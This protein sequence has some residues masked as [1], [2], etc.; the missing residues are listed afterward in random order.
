MNLTTMLTETRDIVGELTADFWT[1]AEL[2]R[3][4]NEAL[5][6]VAGANRWSWLL[7]EGTG[8]IS[9]EDPD[10]ILEDGVAEYR[11]LHLMLTKAGDT[12]P[13]LPE[14]VSPA[15]GFEL[16]TRYYQSQSYPNWFYVT[17]VEDDD[18]DGSFWTTVKFIPTPT[19]DV[20]VEYQYYR[21]P[22]ALSGGNDVP[23][24][25]VQYH[26]ALVHFAAG[27]A[28]LKELNGG[29]KAQEQF[30]LYD[31]IVREAIDDEE[32]QSDD[33]ILIAGGNGESTRRPGEQLSAKDYALLRISPTLGP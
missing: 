14:R 15:R 26:K 5:R 10:F 23:D 31:A 11:H 30:S 18:A 16:R 4:L 12:R 24:V 29:Q 2:T 1:D 20:D 33:T 8:T 13:Y 28:W 27:T 19:E 21:N 17:S 32:S 3:Y 22:V 9:A 7:T 6:R 25:P